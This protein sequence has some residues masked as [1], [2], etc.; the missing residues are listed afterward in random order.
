MKL[1]IDWIPVPNFHGR[2]YLDKKGN[3]YSVRRS[4]F[5]TLI[6]RRKRQIYVDYMGRKYTYLKDKQTD[7]SVRFE[8]SEY[9]AIPH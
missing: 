4:K 5:N 6:I 9:L 2:Y 3:I 1:K 8:I 7:K